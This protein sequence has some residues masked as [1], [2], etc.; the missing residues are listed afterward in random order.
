MSAVV[1]E[2]ELASGLVEQLTAV[3]N[4]S[5]GRTVAW[6]PG[7]PASGDGWTMTLT[8]TGARRGTFLI[9]IDRAGA[10]ALAKLGLGADTAPPD[11]SVANVLREIWSQTAGGLSAAPPFASLSIAIGA[12]V[13]GP[14][15]AQG[16]HSFALTLGPFGQAHVAISGTFETETVVA[17]ERPNF[18]LVLDIELPLVVRFGRTAMSIKALSDLG[19]GSI[20]DMG[21]SPDDPVDILVSDRVIARGEVVVVGGNYG[22]RVT[23][24]VRSVDKTQTVEA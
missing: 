14:A 19:P 15:H 11:E 17:E 2:G 18:G 6:E 12:I 13:P 4:A 23:D 1:T 20:V 24:L 5:A 21:R 3:L 22:V 10:V 8:A 9:W 7:V 16:A